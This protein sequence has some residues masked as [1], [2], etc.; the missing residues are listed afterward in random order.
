M[1]NWNLGVIG[2]G[3]IAQALI[4][5]LLKVHAIEP[6]QVH[7]CARD[8][9]KLY[10]NA[11]KFGVIAHQSVFE[12][13]E[14][15]DVVIMAVKP[16]QMEQIAAQIKGQLKGKLVVTVASKW[17]YDRFD[18]VL[19]EGTHHISMIPNTPIA[20]AQ[21]IVIVEE[22]HSFSEDEFSEFKK[23]LESVALVEVV[24]SE[25]MSIADTLSGCTP[26]FTAM[27]LEALGDAGVKYGLT[28]DMAYRL[29]AQ[30]L[31]GTGA[32]YLEQGKHPGAM[33][34][35]VCSPGGTTI[36]GVEALERGGFRAAAMD[37]INAAMNKK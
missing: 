20:A 23:L 21:G 29:V 31:K 1:T 12:V 22:K 5:G 30:M 36:R 17:N 6:E 37:A 25:H 14:Q 16:Y 28:R 13:I 34:D 18:A 33:K 15:S 26:A 7:V 24:D 10:A 9:K 35:A 2:F 8:L 11:E 4:G 19:M 27:Q 32:L 3:N